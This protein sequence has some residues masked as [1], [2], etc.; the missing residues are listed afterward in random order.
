MI[1]QKNLKKKKKFFNQNGVVVFK[2]LIP[3]SLINKCLK[4]LEKFE[5]KNYSNNKNLVTDFSKNKRYIRYFQ[6]LN[7]YIKSF[8]AFFNSKI[9]NISSSLL[10]DNTYFSSMNYHNKIPGGKATPPHQDNFYWC[11]K[12]KSAL[13]AYIALNNHSSVNGGIEYLLTTHKL[14]TFNHLASKVKGFS[15]FI[16]NSKIDNYKKFKPKLKTGDVI[17]HH[18]NIIHQAGKNNHKKLDRKALALAIY[19]NRSKLDLKLQKKYFKNRN[20]P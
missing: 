20:N 9:L 8:E 14:K 5:A 15:S 18:C 17:F 2:N 6:Y 4:D 16:K 7:I 10:N 11:R 19:S 1:N 3:K 12:P 13:T